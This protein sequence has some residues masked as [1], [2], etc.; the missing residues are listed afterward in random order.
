MVINKCQILT[1]CKISRTH[2]SIFSSQLILI[3]FG[4]TY[5]CV[6]LRIGADAF[7][8]RKQ[9]RVSIAIDFAIFHTKCAK[10]ILLNENVWLSI[11][12]SLKSVPKGPIN[13]ILTLVQ[14][15][16]WRRQGDKPLSEPMVVSLQ[17]HICVTRP[18][19]FKLTQSYNRLMTFLCG[20]RVYWGPSDNYL[21][22]P[23]KVQLIFSKLSFFQ[24]FSMLLL[25]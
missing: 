14:I 24:C 10:G 11:E 20:S 13:A 22:Q 21:V 16:A 25:K 23:L 8:R 4:N 6:S 3:D 19:W 1:F 15:M 7:H 18:Q 12:I 17:R 5:L 2:F 9:T